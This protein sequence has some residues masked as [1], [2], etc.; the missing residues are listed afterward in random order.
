MRRIDLA[1]RPLALAEP[2]PLTLANLTTKSLTAVRPLACACVTVSPACGPRLRHVEEEFLHVPGAG[3][4]A[5]GAEAAVQADVLVLGHDPA[6]LSG[7]GDVEVLR[8]VH[9]RRLQAVA[10]VILLAVGG[11]GDAV[12]R[13]DVDA[14]VALDAE[15]ARRTPSATSQFRQRCA[16]L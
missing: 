3:R 1:N 15:R 4:A 7:V 10:Q 5:L 9:R 13:A 16:S 12:H 6:G 2:E 8:Q 11:E 14:G